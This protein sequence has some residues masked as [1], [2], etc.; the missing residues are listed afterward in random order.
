MQL[1][2]TA[3]DFQSANLIDPLANLAN[4]RQY[5]EHGK[6]DEVIAVRK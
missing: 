1:I 4:G 5:V 3:E 6:N 2:E